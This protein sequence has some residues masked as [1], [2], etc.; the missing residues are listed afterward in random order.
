[1]ARISVIT[2]PQGHYSIAVAIRE[3]LN[4]VHETAFLSIRDSL[5]NLYTPFYQFFPAIYRVPYDLSKKSAVASGVTQYLRRKLMGK[6]SDFVTSTRPDLIVCTNFIFLP[7]LEELQKKNHIP[8]L[9]VITDP[10]T[11]HPLL[12]SQAAETNML[13]DKKVLDT[14]KQLKPKARYDVTGWFVRKSF[15]ETPNVDSIRHKLKLDPTQTTI[16]V[17]GGSEGTM[18][19]LKL[20]PAL[21]QLINPIN[22][23]VLCGS[24]KHLLRSI[25]SLMQMLTTVSNHSRII[26]VGYTTAVADYLAVCD[27]VIGKAGPNTIFETVAAKKPFIAVTHITGQEDGNLDLIKKYQ[28]G[29]VEENPIKVTKLLQS[30]LQHPSKLAALQEPIARLS[31]QNAQ[32][33]DKLLA[34]VNRILKKNATNKPQTKR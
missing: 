12:I 27:L 19:I 1:M 13:F 24:N 11:V 8:I 16:L 28:L 32:A 34:I 7:A 23:I 9:N 20:A 3:A 26:P 15:Y 29:F 31:A 14:C 25:K 4:T 30:V 22:L 10:W 21:L 33:S 17:T 6:M 5:F 2:T 18:M